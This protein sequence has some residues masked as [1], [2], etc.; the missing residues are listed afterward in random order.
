[1]FHFDKIVFFGDFLFFFLQ[2]KYVDKKI[3]SVSLEF[4]VKLWITIESTVVAP[5]SFSPPPLTREAAFY[6]TGQVFSLCPLVPAA[7]QTITYD[8]QTGHHVYALQRTLAE[9]NIRNNFIVETSRTFLQSLIN[10][11]P[12][13]GESYMGFKASELF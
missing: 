3:V 13:K 9:W 12:S 1:M 11:S 7:S 10:T 2:S 4:T 6:S 8:R 5:L